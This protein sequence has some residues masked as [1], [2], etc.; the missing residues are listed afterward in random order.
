MDSGKRVTIT[1]KPSKLSRVL[2]ANTSYEMGAKRKD[3]VAG[4]AAHVAG[5]A[6]QA[7]DA[8]AQQA[9]AG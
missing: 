2:E 8:A 9:A 7:E 5:A 6:A 4:S 1:F 3:K